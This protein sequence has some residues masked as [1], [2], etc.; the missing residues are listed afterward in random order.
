[1]RKILKI[2]VGLILLLVLIAGGF[3]LGVYLRLFDTKALNE[4]YGLH[5]LPPCWLVFCSPCGRGTYGI[6]DRDSLSA[7][8]CGSSGGTEKGI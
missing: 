6:V 2:V 1:M 8:K 5:E 3:A 4:E 7:C